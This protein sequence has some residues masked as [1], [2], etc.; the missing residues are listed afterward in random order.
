MGKPIFYLAGQWPRLHAV[1]LRCNSS[2]YECGTSCAG[3]I[4]AGNFARLNVWRKMAASLLRLSFARSSFPAHLPTAPNSAFFSGMMGTNLTFYRPER[5]FTAH[6]GN[7]GGFV[8]RSYLWC[9][10]EEFRNF[11]R[12]GP[13]V[14]VASG[15]KSKHQ[16]LIKR[17]QSHTR[18]LKMRRFLLSSSFH[19]Q[20]LSSSRIV[21]FSAR[22]SF[23]A[24]RGRGCRRRRDTPAPPLLTPPVPLLLARI[25]RKGARAT[26]A[27]CS[28]LIFERSNLSTYRQSNVQMQVNLSRQIY[29]ANVKDFEVL[30]LKLVKL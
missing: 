18:T 9:L 26:F 29:L 7:W 11:V 21:W 14:R 20:C 4:L 3:R 22:G 1:S 6:I 19:C 16:Q 2:N 13:R 24:G 25:R 15:H 30:K 28:H 27:G 17:L 5:N 10:F 8:F 12:A 23:Q